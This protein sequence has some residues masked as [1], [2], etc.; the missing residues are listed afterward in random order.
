MS[1]DVAFAVMNVREKKKYT[2]RAVLRWKK[3]FGEGTAV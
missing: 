2:A 3:L 1:Q